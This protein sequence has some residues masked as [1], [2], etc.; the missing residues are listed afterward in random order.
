MHSTQEMPELTK[1]TR[2]SFSFRV[3]I[4]NA[5]DVFMLEVSSHS[6]HLTVIFRLC[7]NIISFGANVIVHPV[8][9]PR[10]VI[11]WSEGHDDNHAEAR[12]SDSSEKDCLWRWLIKPDKAKVYRLK[13]FDILLIGH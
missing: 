10:R 12:S 8:L 7:F 5:L 4:S 13:L 6:M 3:R 2:L 9:D 1:H 11:Q